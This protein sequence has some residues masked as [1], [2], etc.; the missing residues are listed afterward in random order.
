MIEHL[1]S[2]DEIDSTNELA[3]RMKDILKNGDIIWALKQTSG[4][5]KGDRIWY[6]PEGGLWFSIFFRPA[7][8][9]DPNVYTKMMAV[10]VIRVLRKFKIDGMGIKWPNDI[11]HEREKVGGILTEI[12]HHGDK[13]EIVV[14][15]G[16][17]VNNDLPDDLQNATSLKNI[18]GKEFDLSHL[19]RR[20]HSEALVLHNFVTKGQRNVI[21]NL[22]RN[23][24]VL[25]KGMKIKLL[26]PSGV[27]IGTVISVFSDSLVVERNGIKER[28]K[29]SEIE[30]L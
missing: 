21:T 5:G 17:N 15:I 9:R 29:P 26:Y 24:I 1:Y 7:T 6:S 28:V 12:I 8:F 16:L 23:S 13:R 22:W 14:G 10:A 27:Q 30:F 3:K 18:T 19:L 11:Y 4:H 20:I 25:K 2:Y